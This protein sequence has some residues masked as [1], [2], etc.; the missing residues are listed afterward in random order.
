MFF[1]FS[2]RSKV[3]AKRYLCLVTQQ[4]IFSCF[5]MCVTNIK[6]NNSGGKGERR[7]MFE[8]KRASR[9]ILRESSPFRRYCEKSRASGTRRRVRLTVRHFSANGIS[10]YPGEVG[11]KILLASLYMLMSQAVLFLSPSWP[12][13]PL[14][15]SHHTGFVRNWLHMVNM[16]SLLTG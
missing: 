6:K 16:K 9:T 12:R 8:W 3:G 10:L 2:F 4:I 7:E 1:C 15:R 13:R 11:Q 14:G 5:A